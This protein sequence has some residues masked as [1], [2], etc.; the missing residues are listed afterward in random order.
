MNNYVKNL[1]LSSKN[2]DVVHLRGGSKSW[3]N[4]SPGGNEKYKKFIGDNFSTMEKY[5]NVIIG[6][7]NKK[8]NNDSS[9]EYTYKH[10]ELPLYILS[11][12]EWLVGQWIKKYG[13][14][15]PLLKNTPEFK[16]TSGCH[17]LS[18]K[19]LEEEGL[20]K[21]DLNYDT[22]LDFHIMLNARNVVFD[23]HS[24]FSKMAYEVG[25]TNSYFLKF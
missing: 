5:F 14:G 4:G 12:S 19:Q 1:K 25:K 10:H 23:G 17:K 22:I 7:Y 18:K 16:S 21:I 20:E 2:Y 24:L 9:D 11:D 15:V 6:D 8:L 3:A 13:L